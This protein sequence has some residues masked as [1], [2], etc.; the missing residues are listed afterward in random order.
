MLLMGCFLNL[1]VPLGTPLPVL[2]HGECTR[3]LSRQ[4]RAGEITSS[5]IPHGHGLRSS[6][7]FGAVL[8]ELHPSTQHPT[9]TSNLNQRLR[10]GLCF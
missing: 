5:P 10:S 3:V 9:L 2:F 7:N 6:Q 1:Q 4:T 8:A